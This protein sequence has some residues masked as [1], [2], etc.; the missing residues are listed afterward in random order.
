M[1]HRAE[2][3]EA[4]VGAWH[5]RAVPRPDP[6]LLLTPGPLTTATATRQAMLRDYG[7]RDDAFTQITAEVRRR[8]VTIAGGGPAHTAIPLQGSGTFCVEAML[9]TFVPPDGRV[10][11]LVNGAYGRRI[12]AL[13]ER[14]GRSVAVLTQPEHEATDVD[15]LAAALASDPAITHVAVVQCETTTGMLNPLADVARV[16]ATAGRRLLVDAMSAFGAIPTEITALQADCVV[17]SSNKCLE[18]PPGVGFAVAPKDALAR[19][20]A[21]AHSVVLDLHAQWLGFE[22]KGQWRFTPPTH[23]MAAFAEALR[24]HEAEGGVAGRGARYRQNLA[25]LCEGMG[26]LDFELFLPPELQAPIIVTFL[27]PA[28]FDFQAFYDGLNKEGYV[29]YPGKLTQ[30]DTFRVGCIGQ[31]FEDDIEAFVKAVRRVTSS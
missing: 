28:G 25:T 29:I 30:R 13:C 10:L 1:T 6:P 26:R 20:A 11:V 23:V 7:S 2:P 27:Q 3:L 21:N 24:A 12:A 9:G 31:V 4:A 17:A 16:T 5:R 8:L 19:T 18:G 15:A 14:I 22:E